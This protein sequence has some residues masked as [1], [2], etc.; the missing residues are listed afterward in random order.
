M[1]CYLVIQYLM[2]T[3]QVPGDALSNGIQSKQDI[4]P[5]PEEETFQEGRQAIRW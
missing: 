5:A 3:S 1:V 4:V 2:S